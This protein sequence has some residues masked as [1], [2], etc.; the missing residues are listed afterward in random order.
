MDPDTQK[1]MDVVIAMR[2]SQ[3]LFFREKGS[4]DLVNAKR[5]E[6]R[7]DQLIADLQDGKT[8]CLP[9]QD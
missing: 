2:K 6:R 3:R 8:N 4:L 9:F 7:V 1:L 5:L